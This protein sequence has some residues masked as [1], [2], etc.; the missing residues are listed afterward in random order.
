MSFSG[1]MQQW[2]VLLYFLAAGFIPARNLW[3]RR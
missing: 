2:F 1:L 3:Q